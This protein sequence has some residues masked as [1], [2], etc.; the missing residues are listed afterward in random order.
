MLR[1]CKRA[2]QE[3]DSLESITIPASVN[4]I[5][6]EAFRGMDKLTNVTFEEAS[7]IQKLGGK[8]F[9]RSH[10]LKEIT[11]PSSLIE[12]S[13]AFIQC[14]GLEKINMPNGSKLKEIKNDAFSLTPNLKEF[15]FLGS[16]DLTQIGTNAFAN[17]TKLKTFDF[18]KSVTSIGRNAFSGCIY[19]HRTTKTNQ[20]YPSVNL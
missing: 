16:C 17:C 12:I 15:N 7:S 5:N 8:V 11:L 19:N 2:F 6:F 10:A 1:I 13:D 9:R 18:P 3:A 20:K 14:N 4:T